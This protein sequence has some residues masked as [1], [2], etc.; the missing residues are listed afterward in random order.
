MMYHAGDVLGLTV[1]SHRA[2]WDGTICTQ[3]ADWQCGGPEYFRHDKC[4]ANKAY[5]NVMHLFDARGPQFDL[6]TTDR[7]LLD[8]AE[9]LIGQVLMFWHKR[10]EEPRGIPDSREHYYVCGIYC[11]ERV[12]K[13]YGN[14][15]RIWP[16]DDGWASFEGLRLSQPRFGWTD[17][18]GVGFVEASA[19]RRWLNQAVNTAL[20]RG[21]VAADQLARIQAVSELVPQWLA[22]C[23]EGAESLVETLGGE[24]LGVEQNYST[25]GPTA[26][27]RTAF[28]ESVAHVESYKK[29]LANV[30]KRQEL[31]RGSSLE[32]PTSVESPAT[33]TALPEP[34]P[35]AGPPLF[36]PSERAA[37]LADY[38]PDVVTRVTL[39]LLTKP[40]LVLKGKPG[41]GKSHLARQL[42]ASPGR[43]LIVPVAS[44]WRGRDDLLGYVNPVTGYFEPTDL[45]RLLCRAEE[46]FLAGDTGGWLVVFEEF[47][48]SPPE[49]WLSDVLARSQ[50][51][52]E[53]KD[54]RRIE[55]GAKGMAD[56]PTR[57]HV[58]L[59]PWI[60]FVATINDDHTT[61]PLSPRVLDRSAVI[62]LKDDVGRAMRGL[63]L[64]EEQ[65]E[66]IKDLHHYGRDSGVCFSHRTG[67]SMRVALEQKEV[68]GLDAWQVIDWILVQEVISQAR[69]LVGDRVQMRMLNSLLS[70]AG[71]HG[72]HLPKTKGRIEEIK[73]L[74]DAGLD[75]R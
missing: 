35:P 70:W 65:S 47:N 5:C 8:R 53:D 17:V 19:A 55:L 50:Y 72:H 28:F 73:R 54:S 60:Q 18:Q 75:A 32:E 46:A 39:S 52:N 37:V 63:D 67:Q 3:P 56:D 68:L 11:V 4:A 16:A 9:A 41:V 7:R 20:D 66:A 74:V 51:P 40:L 34:V 64:S 14:K 22:A 2:G 44:T 29:R 61:R 49:F 45:C 48:L 31:E 62:E 71:S 25:K 42:L 24:H 69:I 59:S 21:S 1:Y 15:I 30:N 38:G 10:A 58:V 12:E 43:K 13:V 23:A 6:R 33:T 26:P 27:L 36:G 57:T